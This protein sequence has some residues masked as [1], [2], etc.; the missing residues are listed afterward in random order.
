[1]VQLEILPLRNERFVGRENLLSDIQQRFTQPPWKDRTTPIAYPLVGPSGVGKSAI[2]L[3][4][5]HRHRED[6][7]YI[8]W[9]QAS[10]RDLVRTSF[11]EI[12]KLVGRKESDSFAERSR[13]ISDC[14]QWFEDHPGWLL[15]FDGAIPAIGS[16]L[17][18]RGVGDIILTS[19]DAI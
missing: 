6:Y 5:A 4:Y 17:P 18:L 10:S 14:Y 3:E 19:I 9:V 2:A 16:F 15:I 7:Q 13:L 11:E 8:F 12:M 1:M